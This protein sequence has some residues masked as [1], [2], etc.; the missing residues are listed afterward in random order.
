[1]E[2]E[3][4]RWRFRI[5]TLMLLII[6][7]G[8]S[9]ALVTEQRRRVLSVELARANQELAAARALQAGWDEALVRRAQ[10]ET[11]GSIPRASSESP[12]RT[13]AGTGR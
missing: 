6:I 2:H 5:S 3:R 1:M 10:D 4:P 11:K 8:L 12:D 7:V 9:I 13:A